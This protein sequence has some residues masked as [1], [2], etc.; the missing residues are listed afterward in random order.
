MALTVALATAITVLT[1]PAVTSPKLAGFR[2]IWT[3][4]CAANDI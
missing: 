1:Q 4:R 3:N 2:K